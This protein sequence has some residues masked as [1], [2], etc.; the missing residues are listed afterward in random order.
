MRPRAA[1]LAA[2]VASDGVRL[3][4]EV[5][6]D[7][8]TTVLMLPTWT[9]VNKRIWKHQ[10]PYLSRHFRVVTYDGPGNGLS[11]RPLDPRAYDHE[12][13]TRHALAVLDATGTDRAVVVGLSMAAAWALELAARHGDR[14]H[15]LV[16]I[17][18]SL[19]LTDPA[20]ERDVA[21]SDEL[22]PSAVP[23]LGTDPQSH[24][25]KYDTDYWLGHYE[26][27]LW[28]FFGQCFPERRSTK[29]IE[30]CVGW[31]LETSAEVLVAEHGST[32]P[33]RDEVVDLCH[34]V[35][36]PVLAIHGSNDHI[37]PMSRGAEVARLTGGELLV[38][39]GGGHGPQSR[40]PVKVNL[41][42]RE[43]AGR[44]RAP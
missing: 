33:E 23:G 7:A 13:Q 1:D 17:G 28:F 35:R 9:I 36:A 42:I 10:V 21:T 22:V 2:Y 5:T 12:V 29:Q 41:V 37:S 11:D 15:G 4:Y 40:D 25:P 24:W 27:F 38:I 26:D 32:Q 14:V 3:H 20:P 16:L 31:G 18:P 30:D 6:G 8:P 19:P 43:F 39:D 44:F 34:R